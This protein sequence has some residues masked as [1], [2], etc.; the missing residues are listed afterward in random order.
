MHQPFK[1]I[2]LVDQSSGHILTHCKFLLHNSLMF[3]ETIVVCVV[4]CCTSRPDQ[5]KYPNQNYFHFRIGSSI[6]NRISFNTVLIY[7]LIWPYFFCRLLNIYCWNLFNHF[8]SLAIFFVWWNFPLNS[9]STFLL[10]SLISAAVHNFVEIR[11]RRRLR[12]K[13]TTSS[14]NIIYL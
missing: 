3:V 7:D 14:R 10:C 12:W 5:H 4:S 13:K 11:Q 6:Y 9:F 8:W 2:L 1:K